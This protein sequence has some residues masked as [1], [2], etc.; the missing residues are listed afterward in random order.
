MH[1]RMN[2]NGGATFFSYH[3]TESSD[4]V[5]YDE[6]YS[7]I[8]DNL[9]V[10]YLSI[11]SPSCCSICWFVRLLVI[12]FLSMHFLGGFVSQ[13]HLS[14]LSF[15]LAVCFFF[16]F[17]SFLFSNNYFYLSLLKSSIMRGLTVMKKSL[18]CISMI[19]FLMS[20]NKKETPRPQTR[21][22]LQNPSF[23]QP[24]P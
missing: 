3:L 21:R 8:T 23:N 17:P 16:L 14:S 9:Y 18:D 2:G 12:H 6:F 1:D 15:S 4:N 24:T 5:W 13:H 11:Y 7:I 10:A 19:Y 22:P 20:Q